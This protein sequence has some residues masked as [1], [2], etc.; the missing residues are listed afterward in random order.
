MFKTP[1]VYLFHPSTSA[2]KKYIILS[3]MLGGKAKQL[4]VT[5]FICFTMVLFP[6]SP[7]PAERT[8]T[9]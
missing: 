5:H 4:A 2:V 6:D 7:A 1:Y 8:K 9:G 3:Y